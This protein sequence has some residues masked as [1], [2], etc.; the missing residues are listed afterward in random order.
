MCQGSGSNHLKSNP[1]FTRK[2]AIR[3][4]NGPLPGRGWLKE[5]VK[6]VA[7]SLVSL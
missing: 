2:Y 6:P 4:P 5:K 1:F 7:A 3:R